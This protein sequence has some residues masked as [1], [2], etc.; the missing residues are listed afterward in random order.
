M[1]IEMRFYGFVRDVVDTSSF[2]LELPDRCTLRDI[3]NLLVERFGQTLRERL[4][5]V[6]GDLEANVRVF[7]G[8]NQTSSLEET[9]QNSQGSFTE[10]KVFVLSATAGG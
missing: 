5:T 8:D 4:F 2:A 9:I 1:H 6:T 3:F 7:V 10:V